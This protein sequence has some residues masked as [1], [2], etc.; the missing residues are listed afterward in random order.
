M[1]LLTPAEVAERLRVTRSTLTYWR[2]TDQ[3]PAFV[4]LGK[5]SVRYPADALEA[6]LAAQE[7]GGEPAA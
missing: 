5:G 6:W 7:R 4:K 3:G 2:S 1:S